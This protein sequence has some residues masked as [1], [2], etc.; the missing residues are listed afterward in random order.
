MISDS[1]NDYQAVNGQISTN[2]R[3]NLEKAYKQ[4]GEFGFMQKILAFAMSTARQQGSL[5]RYCFSFITL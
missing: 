2:E 3:Y 4:V 1:G 5:I